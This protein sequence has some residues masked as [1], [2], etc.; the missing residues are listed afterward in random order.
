MF[1]KLQNLDWIIL[2]S[3]LLLLGIGLFTLFSLTITQ[4]EFRADYLRSEFSSQMVYALIG[5]FLAA[6]VFAMPF[7]YFKLNIIQVIITVFTLLLLAYSAFLGQEIKGV[8]RWII[9]GSSILSDGT[10][11]GGVTIQPSEFAKI[12]VILITSALLSMPIAALSKKMSFIGRVK[13]YIQTHKYIILCLLIN[14]VIIGIVLAQ[15]SLSVTIVISTIA[16]IIIFASIDNKRNAFLLFAGFFASLIM[17]QNFL[18]ELELWMRFAIF[19]LPIGIYVYSIYSEKINDIAVFL[20]IAFGLICGAIFLNLVWNNV[21]RDYQRER[22]EAFVNPNRDTQDEAFQQEQSKISIGAGQFFGQGFREI[23]D[24]R[25][26]L[27]PEPTT[28]FIFAIFSFKFG[29][30]GST[31]LIGLFIVLITRIFYLADKMNDKFSSLI[32]IGVGG[33]I[34]IQFFLNISMN[35]GII[36]VGGTTL[37]FISAGGSSLLTILISIGLVL[38]VIATNSMERTIHQRKD[39]VVIEGWNG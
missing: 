16:A 19:L 21:L 20:T 17:S 37:P 26:L 12:T 15:R 13:D 23:S 33:M 4:I 29:F 8:R 24:S 1:K 27:L 9:I 5:L 3:S 28:D 10:I 22:V 38:N 36:P 34:L 31:I 6:L 25:I 32:L 7:Y 18:F 14:T 11:V 30:V 2:I 39:K 35:L